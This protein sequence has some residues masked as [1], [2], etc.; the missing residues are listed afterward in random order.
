MPI[1]TNLIDTMSFS[2]SDEFVH[3][4]LLSTKGNGHAWLYLGPKNESATYNTFFSNFR[5]DNEYYF[6][7][8][9]LIDYI[10]NAE[11]EY[12][13]QQNFNKEK[14]KNIKG[15]RRKNVSFDIYKEY[16]KRKKEINDIDAAI[17]FYDMKHRIDTRNRFYIQPQNTKKDQPW[18]F[19]RNFALPQISEFIVSKFRMPENFSYK[20]ELFF[21]PNQIHFLD[22]HS[23]IVI[24]N[25]IEDLKKR[26]PEGSLEF[27]RYNKARHGQGFFR[28]E[29]FKRMNYCMITG[30]KEILEAAHIKPWALSDDEEK[31]DNFN[32]ILLTPNCHKLFD[33]GLITFDNKGVLKKSNNLNPEIFYKLIV[34]DKKIDRGPLLNPKTQEYLKWHRKHF[35]NNFS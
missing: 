26:F 4:K 16:P 7:K 14:D 32:G 12:K 28:E 22:P 1:A 9:N 25:S 30:S 31:I 17:R 18:T 10:E 24:N 19:V 35:K 20:F 33:K 3:N 11:Y 29:I 13:N 8:T 34:E 2:V 5:K 21:R 6:S 15:Y 23:D 27:Y